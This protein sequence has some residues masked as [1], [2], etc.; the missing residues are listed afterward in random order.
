[1]RMTFFQR[2]ERYPRHG[3]LAIH[4]RS[5]QPG[6]IWA[7]LRGLPHAAKLAQEGPGP[8]LAANVARFLALKQRA[9]PWLQRRNPDAPDHRPRH[10]SKLL[11]IALTALSG[12]ALVWAAA[13]GAGAVWGFATWHPEP[14]R[15]VAATGYCAC[16]LIPVLW[17][18]S[19]GA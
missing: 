15:L 11:T 4:R 7:Y 1:M 14:L 16:V 6:R 10:A 19:K 13:L 18:D 9:S 8:D 3:P 12:R 2:R 5:R 17:R